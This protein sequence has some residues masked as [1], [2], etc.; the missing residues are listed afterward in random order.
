MFDGQDEITRVQQVFRRD[1][2][3]TRASSEEMFLQQAKVEDAFRNAN[4][5]S[6]QQAEDPGW[7]PSRAFKFTYRTS[8]S[9]T[10]ATTSN[11]NTNIRTI[12]TRLTCTVV[13]GADPLPSDISKVANILD[14]KWSYIIDGLNI[15][16]WV[17]EVRPGNSHAILVFNAATLSSLNGMRREELLSLLS[18][19]GYRQS[20]A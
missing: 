10:S 14:T 4:H 13:Q 8:A 5:F 11:Y 18:A 12:A 19:V 17:R 9:F 15:K 6:I 3:L 7:F 2:Q 16:R 20:S 1:P